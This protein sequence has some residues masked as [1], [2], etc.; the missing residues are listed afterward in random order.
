LRQ[1]LPPLHQVGREPD[2]PKQEAGKEQADRSGVQKPLLSAWLGSGSFNTKIET[3]D[4]HPHRAAQN[5]EK[6]RNG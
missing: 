1:V 6:N 3:I 4:Q 2:N 5:Q